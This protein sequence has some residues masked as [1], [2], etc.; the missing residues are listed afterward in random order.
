[1]AE[2]LRAHADAHGDRAAL[3]DELGAQSW[4][5]TNARVNQLMHLLAG[6]GCEPGDRIALMGRN[7]SAWWEVTLATLQLGVVTIPVNWH[8]TSD[9]LAYVLQ[10]SGSR[11]VFVS[12]EFVEVAHEANARS[13]RP[14]LPI[15]VIDDRSPAEDAISL[16]QAMAAEPEHEPAHQLAIRPMMY[17]SGTTGHPKGVRAHG[18]GESPEEFLAGARGF[19]E[20]MEMAPGRPTLLAGPGYHSA[21][22]SFALL[23][24]VC[25]STLVTPGRLSVTDLL[26]TIDEQRIAHVHLV[27][28]QFVRLLRLSQETKDAFDGASLEVVA[29]GGAP[30][31]LET[32]RRMIDWWGPVITEYYGG[33]ETGMATKITASEWLDRPGSVG[34]AIPTVDL[35]ITDQAGHPVPEGA[36]GIIWTRR[37]GQDFEYHND[38]DKTD[39]AHDRDGFGSGG[40]IG[41]LEDGYLYISGRQIDMII[42]GGV[43][44]YPAEIEAVLHS[45]PAVLD[46]AVV[47][48][49]D[50]E[51]G[52]SVVAFVQ[53]DAHVDDSSDALADTLREHCREL[54]AGYKCPRQFHLVDSLPRSDAG[55]LLKA[56]L[57]DLARQYAATLQEAGS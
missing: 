21:P 16:D 19:L 49:P 31:D 30:C 4:G 46:V 6:M 11:L 14:A 22:W 53:T 56:P 24:F 42:S 54:L 8:W 57:R 35:R 27:P 29:H 40:D 48:I 52:E 44:I 47:G 39:E 12:S 13:E 50:P 5:V 20:L 41:H 28:T 23:P 2:L 15:L 51:F 9:E 17:T 33:T 10:D 45:H 38:P 32:K 3:I 1:M 55:K 43:N 25:G 26:S 7:S 36:T 18:G 37:E 34:R